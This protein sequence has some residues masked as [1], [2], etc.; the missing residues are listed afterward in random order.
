MNALEELQRA[1]S[2]FAD[3]LSGTFAGVLGS[4]TPEFVAES[5]P[6]RPDSTR[7][8][9]HPRDGEEIILTI[10]AQ[11]ALRL[12][13]DFWCSWDHRESFLKV[14]RSALAVHPCSS[15]SEPLFRYDYESM[16]SDAFPSAHLQIHAHRDEFLY[17]LLRGKTGK[18]KVRAQGAL[19]IGGREPHLSQVHF[20][21]GGPRF[22]P[23]V[24][25]VLQLLIAEFCIDT[26]PEAT[27]LLEA[28]RVRWRRRQLQAAV[29]DSP[30]TAADI[31]TDLGYTVTPPV[32]GAPDERL[33]WLTHV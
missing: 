6:K 8:V 14:I 25:D 21:V 1:A 32:G 28:A 16:M 27:K 15:R 10:D 12:T 20:P 31:L 24:E 33:T 22:R 7:V 17:S 11:P 19:G 13:C 23:A 26:E 4:S 18:A 5:G 3:E 30:E 9:V 2:A 29:R